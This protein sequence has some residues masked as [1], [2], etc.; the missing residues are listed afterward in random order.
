MK[1]FL[2]VGNADFAVLAVKA[3]LSS[4]SR[5]HECLR[6]LRLLLVKEV[7]NEWIGVTLKVLATLK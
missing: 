6:A 7:V 4:L 3:Q 1:K 5:T 2:T